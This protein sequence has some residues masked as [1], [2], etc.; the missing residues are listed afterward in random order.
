MPL[1][2]QVG[3]KR[4]VHVAKGLLELC[5]ALPEIRV[6]RSRTHIV[7]FLLTQRVAF[8]FSQ[9]L[10]IFPIVLPR[11][12]GLKSWEGVLVTEQTHR[13]GVRIAASKDTHHLEGSPMLRNT[14]Y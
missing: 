7:A 3:P 4:A 12:L 5:F 10:H 14:S 6:V 1:P 9:V 8:F 2:S 13:D 11:M